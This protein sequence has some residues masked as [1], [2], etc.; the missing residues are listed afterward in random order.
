VLSNIVLISGNIL[1]YFF[2]LQTNIM[3]GGSYLKPLD[4]LYVAFDETDE[5]VSDVSDY[6]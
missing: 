4:L 1:S 3:N 2:F 5:A 6:L